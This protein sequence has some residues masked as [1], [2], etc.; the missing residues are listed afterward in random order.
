MITDELSLNYILNVLFPE[1]KSSDAFKDRYVHNLQMI[2]AII[3]DKVRI[4]IKLQ[5]KIRS[6][7]FVFKFCD[8]NIKIN[9]VSTPSFIFSKTAE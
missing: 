2:S 5:T 7:M 6:F 8:F 3:V 4:T 9:V 1:K